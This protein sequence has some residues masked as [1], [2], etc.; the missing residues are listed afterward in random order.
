[1]TLVKARTMY[2][3]M[4]VEIDLNA[5]LLPS[6]TVDG[7]K[8]K[9]EYEGLHLICFS[10][11]KVGHVTE[12]CPLKGCPIPKE[13]NADHLHHAPTVGGEGRTTSPQEEPKFGGWMVAQDT[14][15]RKN[16]ATRGGK[17]GKEELA[18]K[19]SRFSVLAEE[20]D[21]DKLNEAN[22]SHR[23]ALRDITNETKENRDKKVGSGHN[24][25]GSQKKRG[26]K[27]RVKSGAE[28]REGGRE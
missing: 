3:R 23:G 20:G 1:M 8:L 25:R 12:Y 9:I 14:R 5:P 2:A 22:Q 10:C 21:K 11:G 15:K 28:K 18:V 6:Y 19:G 13:G 16:P 27:T 7:N 26:K 4:C 17:V 24:I